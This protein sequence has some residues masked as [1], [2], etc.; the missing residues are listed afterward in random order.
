[1]TRNIQIMS[2]IILERS[3]LSIVLKEV[4]IGIIS[5]TCPLLN[6]LLLIAKICTWD[7]SECQTN[8]RNSRSSSHP[9]YLPLGLRGCEGTFSV[10]VHE[11]TWK[12]LI[13]V[14]ENSGFN[15]R[16]KTSRGCVF[17]VT[18][19]NDLLIQTNRT[20]EILIVHF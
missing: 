2:S 19:V 13:D 5:S 1:M 17:V 7:C 12:K 18:A 4:L 15:Q 10:R 20:A 11:K 3:K 6:Y 16:E 8:F 14:Y 9:D